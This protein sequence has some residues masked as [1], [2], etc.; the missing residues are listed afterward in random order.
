MEIVEG[1]FNRLSLGEYVPRLESQGYDHLDIILEHDDEDFD[2]FG[3][4]IGMKPGHLFLLKKHVKALKNRRTPDIRTVPIIEFGG[5]S[6]APVAAA[7]A[8]AA[9]TPAPCGPRETVQHYNLPTFCKDTEEVKL[10]SY[11]HSTALGYAAMRDNK[12]GKRKDCISL[13]VGFV[14]KG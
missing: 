8:A 12:S 14:Q 13:Q 3:R 9:A 5:N 6:T 10:E 1:F 11:R 4:I 2:C 7:A